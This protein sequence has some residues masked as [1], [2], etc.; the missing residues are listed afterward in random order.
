MK[1]LF[2]LLL[3]GFLLIIGVSCTK[4]MADNAGN[5]VVGPYPVRNDIETIKS[6]GVTTIVSLLDPGNPYEDT[7]LIR[8]QG[9][10]KEYGLAVQNF[11]MPLDSNR[12]EY[13]QIAGNAASSI[14]SR[15]G[16]VYLHSYL[17][18]T[19]TQS[20]E[21]LLKEKGVQIATFILPRR[22]S[23]DITYSLDSA[24]AAYQ[25]SHFKEVVAILCNR[26]DLDHASQLLLGWAT[27]HLN[28]IPQAR[29]RFDSVRREH[30]DDQ[31]ANVGVAYCDYRLH[32]LHE[33][34]SLFSF[35]LPHHPNDPSVNAG[36]GLVRFEEGKIDDARKYLAASLKTDSIN[37]EAGNLLLRIDSMK[38]TTTVATGQKNR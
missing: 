27:Y 24:R 6:H 31:E 21:Q 34:D 30:P 28:E 18:S 9:Y 11:P 14:I 25:A 7:L 38:R 20:V 12:P 8:E 35:E 36:L 16:K 37:V 3:C 23:G 22:M 33:S 17:T 26:K 5:V 2:S 32:N 29:A 10:A 13:G 1:N 19:R 4:H 15:G